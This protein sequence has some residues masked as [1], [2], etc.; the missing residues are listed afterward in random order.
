MQLIVVR[1]ASGVVTWFKQ[2]QDLHLH[3]WICTRDSFAVSGP[4][5][6]SEAEATAVAIAGHSAGLVGA[7]SQ[8][9]QL[10]L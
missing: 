5:S 2:L 4:Q 1:G 8:V 6:A 10:D 7:I 9:V 3:T